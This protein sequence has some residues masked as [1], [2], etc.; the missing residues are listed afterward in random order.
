M[1]QSSR[2]LTDAILDDRYPYIDDT[3]VTT[4]AVKVAAEEQQGEMVVEMVA[5]EEEVAV[6]VKEAEATAK[7]ER[8]LVN[9]YSPILKEGEAFAEK[10]SSFVLPQLFAGKNNNNDS[11][12][13]YQQQLQ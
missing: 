9:S 3:I 7:N 10:S 1:S 13:K 2:Y 8:N 4:L 11:N 12:Q 5:V 6:A